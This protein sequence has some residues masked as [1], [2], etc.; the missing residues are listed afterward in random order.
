MENDEPQK[1]Y[2]V[3]YFEGDQDETMFVIVRLQCFSASKLVDIFLLG[4]LDIYVRQK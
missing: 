2:N 4:V 3:Q 1:N